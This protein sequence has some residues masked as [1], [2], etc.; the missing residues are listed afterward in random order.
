MR[1][2]PKV[3]IKSLYKGSRVIA[4]PVA[5][6]LLKQVA[7]A[8]K[9]IIKPLRDNHKRRNVSLLKIFEVLHLALRNKG[10]AIEKKK[11]IY[12]L[13]KLNKRQKKKKYS[14]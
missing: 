3:A 12:K 2:T 8:I 4:I 10:S 9:F 1:I 7:V 14:R 11:N 13:A 6:P 5:L